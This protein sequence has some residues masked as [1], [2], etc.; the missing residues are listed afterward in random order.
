MDLAI[1]E[2]AR[3]RVPSATERAGNYPHQFSGGMR[4]RVVA[5]MAIACKP[6]LLIA[7]EPTSALDVTIQVQFM[8]LIESIQA[9]TGAGLLFVTHDLG[10]A[11]SLCHR[12]AVMY[13]G[14][15]VESADVRTLYANPAHPYTQGLL[16]SLPKLGARQ[17]RL[18]SIKGTP[19]DPL[20]LPDGC[21]FHPRCPHATD[22]CRQQAPPSIDLGD[23][24]RA[25]CWLLENA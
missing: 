12:I 17:S 8:D 16:E 23:G 7:D 19:P 25:S 1:D 11:A 18:S 22:R 10:V 13:A 6:R 21:A 14:Q 15:I 4:Q 5:A 2:L 24:Q 20:S 9:E 3:V